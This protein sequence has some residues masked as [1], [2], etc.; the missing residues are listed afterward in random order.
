M[1]NLHKFFNPENIP[2]LHLIWD[3]YYSN[4]RLLGF[5]QRGSFWWKDIVKLLNQ[6]KGLASVTPSDSK[7]VLL[8]DDLWL[9]LVPKLEFPELYSFAKDKT[10]TLLHA[11]DTQDMFRLFHLPLSTEAYAQLASLQRKLAYVTPGG[12][13]LRSYIWRTGSFSSQ[14]AY[15]HMK[16][17]RNVHAS[18]KWIWKSSCQLKHKIF[19]WLICKDRLNTRGI[20]RRRN[21]HPEDY[22]CVF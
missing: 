12:K 6:D 18:F 7:T 1:K 15:K 3:N 17:Y 5:S 22:S 11:S 9:G 19:F 8:W 21:M 20:L 16:G 10:S 14:K 2:W 13:D 4:G